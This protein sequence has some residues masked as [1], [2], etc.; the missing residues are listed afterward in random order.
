[1]EGRHNFGDPVLV[2][3]GTAASEWKL[4]RRPALDGIRAL[5]VVLVL[6][7]HVRVPG[8]E[9]VGQVGVTIFFTLSGF[10]IS[11][12]LLEELD[13]NGSVS[14]GDFYRRRAARLLPALYALIT[15]VCVVSAISDTKYTSPIFVFGALLYCSN[16][17]EWLTGGSFPGA[18]GH[19][20]TLVIEEQFYLLW[21]LA[22]LALSRRSRLP[23]LGALTGLGIVV[24]LMLRMWLWNG[25]A[26]IHH[27]TFGTD[28]RVD[29]LLVGCLLALTLRRRGLPVTCR[30]GVVVGLLGILLISFMKPAPALT[31]GL[32][33]V[34]ALTALLITA[35]LAGRRV[36]LLASRPLVWLGRRSYGFYLW[37]YPVAYYLDANHLMQA[38][39]ELRIVVIVPVSLALTVA[40]WRWIEQPALK[41]W[42]W[43]R[44]GAESS[45]GQSRLNAQVSADPSR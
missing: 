35:V 28:T 15:V 45:R 29:G 16:V 10:L 6:L 32:T 3:S 19:T 36:R 34:A 23:L 41:K 18:L 24:P 44:E 26:G 38:S 14:L 11:T 5:A 42:R 17:V 7:Q 1:M 43:N 21:P 9:S 20:W 8:L 25:G 2:G 12:I 39:W 27:V 37:H 40:S 31:V 33:V 13:A 4:G 30:G 22:L